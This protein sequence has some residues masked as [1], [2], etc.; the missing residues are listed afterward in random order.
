MTSGEILEDFLWN[1]SFGL[2][3]NLVP[4][5]ADEV[6]VYG[7]ILG[8]VFGLIGGSAA[9]ALVDREIRGLPVV[10]DRS[11]CASCEA[12]IAWYDNIPLVSYLVLKGRCR[13]CKAAIPRSLVLYEVIGGIVGAVAVAALPTP[14]A[15]I[16]AAFAVLAGVVGAGVDRET[17]LIPNR[18][19]YPAAGLVLVLVT[20][21]S[22][23]TGSLSG[24]VDSLVAGAVLVALFW[25]IRV[26]SR[27]GMGLGDAKLAG[28]LGLGIGILG[29]EAVFVMVLGAF[30]LGSVVGVAAILRGG[31]T[32]RARMP[33]GPFL[34]ASAIAV[35][36]LY[37]VGV[38]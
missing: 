37:A 14:F 22:I 5:P 6:R 35:L 1:L 31:A 2:S 3:V 32:M 28:L 19:T 10:F 20:A 33:F 17:M 8:A 26:V 7:M 34:V 18:V 24:L 12:V 25:L 15:A 13:R 29:T 4:F 21:N 16:A 30:A 38:I 27:G 9:A 23:A 36:A 11:R